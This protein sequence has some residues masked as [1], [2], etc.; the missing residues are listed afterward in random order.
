MTEFKD[1]N[2]EGGQTQFM[3]VGKEP[4]LQNV[5]EIDQHEPI[6]GG[7]LSASDIQTYPDYERAFPSFCEFVFDSEGICPN[8]GRCYSL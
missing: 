1:I 3:D 7:L 4:R 2:L 6:L 5:C 8:C